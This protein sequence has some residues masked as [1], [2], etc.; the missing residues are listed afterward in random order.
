MFGIN[1]LMMHKGGKFYADFLAHIDALKLERRQG[2]Q[3][4]GSA[5]DYVVVYDIAESGALRGSSWS[6]TFHYG[7]GV[8]G[9]NRAIQHGCPDYAMFQRIVSEG[10][11]VLVRCSDAGTGS[12]VSIT[13]NNFTSSSAGSDARARMDQLIYFDISRGGAFYTLP[14]SG[15]GEQ[16][17]IF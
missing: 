6:S 1:P 15:T 4:F 8:L 16:P 2:S 7:T 3:S 10:T 12:A 14:T 11:E 17:Y 13:R 9:L 5:F